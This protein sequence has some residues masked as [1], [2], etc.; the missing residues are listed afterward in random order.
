M[1]TTEQNE[2]QLDA[3][4]RAALSGRGN[5]DDA[6]PAA[7]TLLGY[8]HGTLPAAEEE[9]LQTHLAGCPACV[10][11]LLALDSFSAPVTVE[12]VAAAGT[13][14]GVEATLARLPRET[15]PATA[16]PPF[17]RSR[18]TPYLPLAAALLLAAL[19]LSFFLFHLWQRDAAELSQL[20]DQYAT[21]ET[22]LADRSQ[23]R[24]DLPIVDLFPTGFSRQVRLDRPRVDVPAAADAVML[25]LAPSAPVPGTLLRLRLLDGAGEERWTGMATPNEAGSLTVLLP[26]GTLTSGPY[27]LQL[28]A[29]DP[30]VASDRFPFELDFHSEP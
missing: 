17:S 4:I 18:A 21:L 22:R 16:A 5:I 1:S 11:L 12:E 28:E 15:T 6:H 29:P 8:H 24:T 7:D 27:E 19:G 26:R 9:A 20:R 2:H 13:R 10:R 30:T 25:I 14:E 23:P 3:E